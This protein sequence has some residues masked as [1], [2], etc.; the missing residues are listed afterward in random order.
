MSEVIR[1]RLENFRNVMKKYGIDAWI[2]P[3]NDFHGS[4]YIGEHF[5]VR[6][7]LTGFTGSVGTVTVTQ[8]GAWL[9]V[10]GRYF[11]QA[12]KQLAGTEVHLFKSGQPNVPLL[13][14]FL[15]QELKSGETAGFD[16]RVLSASEGK[17]TPICFK[18]K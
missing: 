5:K 3:T 18:R 4:E 13:E 7:Y 1:E 16:G 2:A 6:K 9:W 17:K 12:E 10:D 8:K 15:A 14:E 11:V